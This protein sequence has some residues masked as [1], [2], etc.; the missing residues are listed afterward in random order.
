MPGKRSDQIYAAL[1][2]EIIDWTLPPGVPLPEEE[3]A[4]RLGAS[5]TPVRE[6]LQ[7]LSADGL[8]RMVPGKGSF[9]AD[10]SPHEVVEL[11][12]IRQALESMAARL[13]ARSSRRSSLEEI[14]P[15]LS[16]ARVSIQ[17]GATDEYYALTASLDMAVVELAGNERLASSLR[18]VWLQLHRARRLASMDRQRLLDTVDEHTAIVDAIIRGDAEAAALSTLNHLEES[19]AYLLRTLPQGHQAMMSTDG[20]AAIP[21][22]L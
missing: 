12:Q 17:E 19:L 13:A 18:Q 20:F 22:G 21:E 5:R 7:R 8:V 11:S 9:V 14:L 2:A 4:K 6:A 16:A 3:V 1:R 15:A 10:L